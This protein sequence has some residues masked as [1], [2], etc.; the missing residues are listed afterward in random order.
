MNMNYVHIFCSIT[1]HND[2]FSSFHFHP[3]YNIVIFLLVHG[4]LMMRCLHCAFPAYIIMLEMYHISPHTL[5]CCCCCC[6]HTHIVRMQNDSY[7]LRHHMKQLCVF[8]KCAYDAQ[9]TIPSWVRFS[10]VVEWFRWCMNCIHS[11]L[12]RWAVRT[13]TSFFRSLVRSYVRLFVYTSYTVHAYRI[14]SAPWQ[15]QQNHQANQTRLYCRS[16]RL[17]FYW[18]SCCVVHLICEFCLVYLCTRERLKSI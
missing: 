18:S 16:V 5:C 9:A 12:C 2:F 1:A 3:R 6:T 10:I 11:M 17:H 7:T 4:A 13:H 14:D 15:W 8:H